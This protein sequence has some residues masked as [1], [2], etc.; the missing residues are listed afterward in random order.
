MRA[1]N[2]VQELQRGQLT[3]LWNRRRLTR[4]RG[5]L[6]FDG[7]IDI[8]ILGDVV[9][10]K[11]VSALE[12]LFVPPALRIAGAE[13]AVATLSAR[14]TVTNVD[15]LLDVARRDSI[16]GAK[17]PMCTQSASGIGASS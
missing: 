16:F 12:R 14:V 7:L 11:S 6:A 15:D 13:A 17:L 3:A 9:L 8:A 5:I 1:R 10:I 2:P 4:A